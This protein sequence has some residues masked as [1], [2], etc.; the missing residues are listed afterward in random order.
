MP[1]THIM[2]IDINCEYCGKS[3]LPNEFQVI[4]EDRFG[5]G[6]MLSTISCDECYKV[7]LSLPSENLS[8]I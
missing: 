5:Y 8:D 4:I 2:D 7:Y 3:V 1:Y 6:V